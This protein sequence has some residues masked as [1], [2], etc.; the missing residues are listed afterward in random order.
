MMQLCNKCNKL[1]K[2][3]DTVTV[4]VTATYHILKSSVAYALDRHGMEADA[5]TLC[6]LSCVDGD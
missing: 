4:K 5:E 3:G 2:E 1:L 6:H